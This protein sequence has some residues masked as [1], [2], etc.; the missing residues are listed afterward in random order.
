MDDGA[1]DRLRDA[2]TDLAGN[3][4]FLPVAVAIGGM[5]GTITGP[6]VMRQ[7]EGRLPSNRIGEA[8]VR[9]AQLGA[10]RELPFP[11]RPNPHVFEVVEGPFWTHVVDGWASGV[12]TPSQVPGQT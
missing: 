11:G 9:L 2:S 1:F 6:G 10:L 12:A 8:L 4:V 3:N 7:L 5:Q